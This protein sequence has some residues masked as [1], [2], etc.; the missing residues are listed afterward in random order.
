VDFFLTEEATGR[1][2]RAEGVLNHAVC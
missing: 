1:V 2:E